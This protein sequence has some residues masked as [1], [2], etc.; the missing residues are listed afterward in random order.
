VCWKDLQSLVTLFFV[1][2]SSVKCYLRREDLSSALAVA[3][4]GLN[5]CS[6]NPR[7][8][9]A[10]GSVLLRKPEGRVKAIKAFQKVSEDTDINSR[11][12]IFL[13]SN[14]FSP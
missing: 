1:L 6:R 7:A 14:F 13:F 4:I 5:L 10:M 8:L 12:L 9:S 3:K 2:Q 11:V